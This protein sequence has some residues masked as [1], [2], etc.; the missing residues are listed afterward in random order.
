MLAILSSS[1]RR[2][3]FPVAVLVA[4]VMLGGVVSPTLSQA[5]ESHTTA[6][7]GRVR[8]MVESGLPV[9][10]GTV[11]REHRAAITDAWPQ[12][13]ALFSA[14]P[15]TLQF[16]VFVDVVDP[17][18]TS[19]MHWVNDFT[20]V[21]PDGSTTTIAAEPFLALTPIEATN[22][23]RNVLSRG[24]V[25]AAAG[26]QM[27]AGLLAGIARYVETP[28]L[29]RQAR[30]GSLVQG[31]D[32]SGALP[33]W[34]QIVTGTAPDL[35]AEVQTAN[36]YALVAFL[37]DR[38]GIAGLRELVAGFATSPE[39]SANLANT[40]GQSEGDL[41]S[42]WNQFLPR[43]FASG[44]RDNAVSAFD[45]SRA[46]AL[47]SRG[48]YEAAAAEA[49]RSQRLFTDLDDQVG[50]SRVETL[51]AQ[52][53]VGLQVDRVMTESQ[54]AL[55]SNAYNDVLTLLA[56]AEELYGL[57]PD[58]HRSTTTIERYDALASDGAAADLRLDRARGAADNW[59]SLTSARDD[60]VSAGDTYA[61]LGNG[62]GVE[63][64][65][66]IVAE[67]DG[68]IQRMVFVL[69]ALV[70]V[71]CAWLGVWNWQRSPGRLRWRPAG[72]SSLRWHAKAGGD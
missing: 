64:S 21:S 38:Y 34:D 37:T 57:L 36:A 67:I 18:Q 69:S 62:D 15:A 49:E 33:G 32:Q 60:A 54:T 2:H 48:A 6:D 22:V 58:A 13:T 23:L 24:F 27:P 8:I 71:L 17:I 56:Q 70:I 53:A 9:D 72:P 7:A 40:F 35:T 25:Q 66:Q 12:F 31:L 1:P 19:E 61:L 16:I 30:L 10:A 26:G 47:F 29:A 41:A 46:E 44:W 45:L 43:W 20:Y 3:R 11:A 65:S 52:C 14:E 51:L 63:A 59:L 42:G 55:E 50:L 5:D 39:W 68:R 4:I 28:V